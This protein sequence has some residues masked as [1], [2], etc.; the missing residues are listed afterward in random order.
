VVPHQ[1]DLVRVPAAVLPKQHR[2]VLYIHRMVVA[3][4]RSLA[5]T[6]VAVGINQEVE[7][8]AEGLQQ[9]AQQKGLEELVG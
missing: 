8:A 9:A 7:Q 5:Q 6:V 2:A 3:V 4:L 1:L